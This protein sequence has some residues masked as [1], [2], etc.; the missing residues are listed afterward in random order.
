[1]LDFVIGYA[2][3][4]RTAARAASYAR[5]SAVAEVAVHTNRVEDLN[6]RINSLAMI[7]RAMWALL[8]EQGLSH[9][10]LIAKLDELDMADGIDDGKM[11]RGAIDCPSCDSKVAPG[12]TKCQFCGAEIE[13]ADNSPLGAI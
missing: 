10:Q 2:A 7:I 6:E 13:L 1:M 9:E 12:L 5:S 8:E 3:G 11:R 4:S